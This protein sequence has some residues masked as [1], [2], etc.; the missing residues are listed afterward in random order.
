MSQ[1][2][3]QKIFDEAMQHH[4]AGRFA[5]AIAAFSQVIALD[6]KIFQAHYNLGNAL[7]DNG[8]LDDA[9]AAYRRAI[10]INPNFAEAYNNLGYALKHN[11]QLDEA[12]SAAG[13]ALALRPDL[14]GAQINL[15]NCLKDKGQFDAAVNAYRRASQIKSDAYRGHWNLACMLLSLGRFAE[16]WEEYEYRLMDNT[17]GLRR[18]FVH[19][20]WNGE[21]LSG[22][23][24]LLHT[25]GGFGDAIQFIR[26]VPLLRGRAGKMILECQP[27]VVRLFSDTSGI[28][29]IIPRGNAIPV[30]DYHVPLQSLPR[31][32]K[33]DLTNIPD[34]VPY[35]KAPAEDR[36][37][38]KDRV[39]RD[40]RLNV[41]LMW[42]GSPR[43][44]AADDLRSRG[45]DVF[46]PLGQISGVR[47]FSLQKGPESS[48]PRPAR[49][50][51]IDFTSD[52]HDFADTAALIE[53]LDLVISVDTSVAHLTGALA[54]PVWV[55]IPFEPD[56]RWLLDRS[57]SPWYPT[58]RLFR[59][60]N[61]KDWGAAIQRIA[62]ALE[63]HANGQ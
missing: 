56:F 14:P 6:P 4:Q 48:L 18:D 12:I 31:I 37:R 61:E 41:G 34:A 35:L 20:K 17:K 57:D 63:E 53:N 49:L 24:L 15:G 9:V 16:G 3:I 25:E 1:Q 43:K 45:L 22:K 19:P 60:T 29:E 44:K 32:F 54:K 36:L 23:T 7:K 47:F 13:Q 38:W 52:L 30:F 11:G 27:S 55:L 50:E 2:A 26:Y 42:A 62:I 39:P 40:G 21:D 51:I 8:Q 5:E 10:A 28:E 58:M 33:T 59:Q 46:A